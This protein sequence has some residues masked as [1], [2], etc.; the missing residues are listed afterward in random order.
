M[1]NPIRIALD[2]M[3]GDNAPISVVG[4][5][6]LAHERHPQIQF[7]FYG[8]Q[9]VLKPLLERKR[10]I[11]GSVIIHT[12]TVIAN[13]A[14][15]SSA[16]RM[17]RKSSM[18]MAIDAV[19]T[20]AADCVVSA[21][22]TGALL[23]IGRLAMKM[24]PGIDRPAMA[25]FFP[26]TRGE[27]VMLDLGANLEC[28]AENL[29]QFAF[30]GAVFA[31]SVLGIKKPSIG[32]LNVGSE[33]MKGH[34]AVRDAAAILRSATLPG[35][36][37]GFV[38]GNDIATGKTDVVVTDGFSGNVALKT[39]EGLSKLY[40][41]FLHRTFSS[42]ILARLGGLL[43]RNA[44]KKLKVRLDPRRYNGAVFLGLQGVCVKSHGGA[45]AVSFANAISVAVDMVMQGANEKIRTGVA[46]AY[47]AQPTILTPSVA[48]PAAL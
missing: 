2:A 31:T 26:T 3:G 47:A 23:A 5:A 35:T 11:A 12:D 44:F 1:T 16:L 22:N 7:Q 33:E 9:S 39:S 30:M 8:D 21:G 24:L 41:E 36:F 15:T 32:I 27:S 37:H 43:A 40:V 46:E 13:D 38:E 4:G 34:E 29:A 25:S 6:A 48:E 10:N 19:A 45:D 14:K 28:T 18:G 17:R 42:S 20:G